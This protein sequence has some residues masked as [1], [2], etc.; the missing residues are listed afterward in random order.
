MEGTGRDEVEALYGDAKDH[1]NTFIA[2]AKTD[3]R[4]ASD[5]KDAKDRIIVIDDAIETFKKMDQIEKEAEAIARQEAE[6]ARK[7][8]ERLL[9]LERKAQ[10]Q[11]GSRGRF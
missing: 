6:E 4:F 5:V 1:F 3:G 2:K 8:R 11:T 9:E 10:E 7:E